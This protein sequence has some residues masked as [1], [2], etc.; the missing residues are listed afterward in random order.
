MN[1]GFKFSLM[2]AAVLLAGALT[3]GCGKQ[4]AAVPQQQAP[5]PE[6]G[7]LT[8]QPQPVALTTELP[9][10]TSAYL[11]AEVR[12]QVGGII[13]RRLFTEGSDV[14]EGQVLYQ[15]DPATYQAAYASA[16][17][18]LS[19]ADANI[20]PIRLKAQRYKELVAMN[21]V[22]R[23]DFDDVSAQLKAAEAEIES[24]KAAVE[25]ARI[26]LAYTKVT[27]PISGRIGRSA[28]TP[29]ALVTGSQA[30]PL[31]TI[32]RLDDVYV[33]VTQSSAEL[34]KLKQT[35]ASGQIKRGAN[36]ATV[37]LI[38]E[39]GTPYPLAGS[40]KFSD[41]TVDPSTGSVTLRTV[42]PNP[43]Q[44]LL[45][46]MYVRAVIQEGVSDQAI[47]VPQRGVTRNPAGNAMVFVVGKE[48]KVE[49][50]II[51][52]ERTVGDSW[53]VSDGL[54]TGDRVILEGIQKAKPGTKVKTVPF[55]AKAEG[56]TGTAGQPAP[57]GQ[58]GAAQPGAAAQPA[59]A[60]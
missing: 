37:K 21:A 24:A 39:D 12:P 4:A 3:T 33:D 8:V 51:K 54:K 30:T 34:L 2:T 53:L 7:I 22:S 17:A 44:M 5:T 42:F 48:E 38:L 57:A 27:A 9:G 56:M 45:P 26:N 1:A 28:V 47:M 60:K 50:R 52:V 19:R 49:P 58:P 13:Q 14:K 20:I 40:L 10:R 23:Q 59:K 43:K 41:V 55:V 25:T 29:G 36:Q 16:K 15:I 6:V 32:Q 11:V 46:G 35:L 18:A 31:A